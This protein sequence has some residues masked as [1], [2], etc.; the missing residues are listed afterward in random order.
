[1][2]T[3]IGLTPVRVP[4]AEG[5]G[6][7]EPVGS[8]GGIDRRIGRHV[9]RL[10]RLHLA[11]L[12][13]LD[14]DN[15]FAGRRPGRLNVEPPAAAARGEDVSKNRASRR[16]E[17]FHRILGAA[18]AGN[19]RLVIDLNCCRRLHFGGRNL[20]LRSPA[21]ASLPAPIRT[22]PGR[23]RGP[24]GSVLVRGRSARRSLR[25]AEQELGH[26]Q[27][28]FALAGEHEIGPRLAERR[29]LAEIVGTGDDEDRRV[30]LARESDRLAARVHVC[31]G[32]DEA[33][34]VLDAGL[35]QGL[36]MSGV[37]VDRPGFPGC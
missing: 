30:E 28:H 10:A 11:A 9:D 8:I 18:H 35:L 36:A 19:W 14:L 16:F 22:S 26:R 29:Q 34:G 7:V 1:M 15:L 13:R 31:A 25:V 37:A 3:T 24:T 20:R 17:V 27:G 5:D 4:D 21:M 2:V 23:R 32:E 33:D 6:Q 12:D